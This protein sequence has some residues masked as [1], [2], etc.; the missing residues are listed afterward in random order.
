MKLV[1]YDRRLPAFLEHVSDAMGVNT[2]HDLP[3]SHLEDD[4]LCSSPADI[5]NKLEAAKRETEVDIEKIDKVAESI[6]K[7][8]KV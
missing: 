7:K 6:R 3:S 5:L 1:L 8:Y 2:I 4:L